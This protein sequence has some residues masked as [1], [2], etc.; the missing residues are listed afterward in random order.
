LIAEQSPE[1]PGQP[2]MALE[3]LVRGARAA[4]LST[5]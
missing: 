2:T 4:I 5:L 1:F 3:E